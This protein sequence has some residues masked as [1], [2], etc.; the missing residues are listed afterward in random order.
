MPFGV[1]LAK[2]IAVFTTPYGRR[3]KGFF[4]TNFDVEEQV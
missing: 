3:R 2:G 1:V 4:F